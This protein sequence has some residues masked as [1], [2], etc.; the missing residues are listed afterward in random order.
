MWGGVLDKLRHLKALD[1]QC[2]A[3]GADTHRYLLRPC[4]SPAAIEGVERRLGV[5]LPATLRS[6]YA[7][8]TDRWS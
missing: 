7:D 6:F 5:A 4:L 1:R 3:F 8:V 2:Q